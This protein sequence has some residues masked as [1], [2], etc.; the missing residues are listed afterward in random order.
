M[1]K[2][3][4]LILIVVSVTSHGQGIRWEASGNSYLRVADN[5][6]VRHTL[7]ANTQTTIV[8]KADLTPAGVNGSI[9]IRNYAFSEDQTKLLIYTNTKQVWRLDTRGDYWVLDLTTKK[10]Q[11]L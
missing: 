9:V 4:I 7:P 10:L 1:K 6:L 2:I 5:Q 11:Q 8:S 3:I